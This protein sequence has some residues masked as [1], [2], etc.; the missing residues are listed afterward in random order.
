MRSTPAAMPGV[1]KYRKMQDLAKKQGLTNRALAAAV[2]VNQGTVTR[3]VKGEAAPSPKYIARLAELL[4]VEASELYVVTETARNLAYYRIL[5]GYSLAQL[6]PLIGT[7]PVHLGRMEAGR[8]SIPPQVR[9]KLKEHLNID[10]DRLAK[11]IR[12]SQTR[13]RAPVARPLEPYEFVPAAQPTRR[14]LIGA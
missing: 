2:D 14:E 10:E 4:G 12:R 8:S 1:F 5:A 3:W 9:D 11:A 13:R 7:S 6:A